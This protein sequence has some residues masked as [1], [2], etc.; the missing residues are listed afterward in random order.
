MM[1]N[2]ILLV[3]FVLF[4]ILFRGLFVLVEFFVFWFYN[5]YNL[6]CLFKLK[7]LDLNNLSIILL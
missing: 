4:L 2:F 5:E 3:S 7:I 1:K 6:K